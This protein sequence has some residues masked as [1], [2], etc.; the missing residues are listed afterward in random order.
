MRI[1]TSINQV[2]DILHITGFAD[3][4]SRNVVEALLQAPSNIVPVFFSQPR[5]V[6]LN[7]RGVNTLFTAQIASVFDNGNQFA[8]AVVLFQNLHI[9]QAVVEEDVAADMNV[10]VQAGIADPD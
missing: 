9:Q 8:L 5:Q 1:R 10:I 6:D 4:G 7:A 2:P 3:E